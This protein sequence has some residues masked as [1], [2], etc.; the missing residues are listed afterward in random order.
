MFTALT[1]TLALGAPVPPTPDAPPAGTAPRLVELKS[2]ANGKI[3]V[4]VMR[5]EMQKVPVAAPPAVAGAPP[6]GNPAPAIREV[7]VTRTMVVELGDVKDLA[8]TTAD[9]KKLEK[10]EGLK[11]LG[12]GGIVVI[13]G[14]GKPVSPTFLKVF[15]DDTL[16]LASPEL[17]GPQMSGV[18]RPVPGIDR[19]AGVQILPAAPA[20]GG[21]QLQPGAIQVQI[22]PAAVPAVPVLPAVPPPAKPPEK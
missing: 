21:I 7:P 6:G 13:S 17:A 2:D 3:T 11:K 15:K 14:D 22:A 18:M 9:G 1:L 19:P 8:I 20:A 5:T 12:K 16:V 10:E 4:T